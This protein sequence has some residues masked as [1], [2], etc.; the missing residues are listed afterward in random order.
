MT[1]TYIKELLMKFSLVLCLLVAGIGLSSLANAKITLEDRPIN[2]WRESNLKNRQIWATE[3]VMIM[4][5]K[6]SD[7]EL[8]NHPQ[9]STNDKEVVI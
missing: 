7:Q 9:A 8:E 3:S 6:G 1:S 5:Q 2:D 4:E